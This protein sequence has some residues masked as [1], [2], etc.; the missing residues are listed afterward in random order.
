MLRV[1][2]RVTG[3]GVVCLLQYLET[4]DEGRYW[5]GVT[6]GGGVKNEQYKF[7]QGL[8]TVMMK[9]FTP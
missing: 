7:I 4:A 3:V 9:T 1:C 8:A 2:W 6:G 5:N